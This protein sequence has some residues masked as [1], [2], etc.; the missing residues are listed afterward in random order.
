MLKN[1][2]SVIWP[3]IKI[4]IFSFGIKLLSNKKKTNLYNTTNQVKLIKFQML[5]YF[6]I[7]IHKFRYFPPRFSAGLPV[8][9]QRNKTSKMQ[10][11][12]LHTI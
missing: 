5:A 6:K 1:S 12:S 9:K 7:T 2:F 3:F 10:C 8:T 4:V 11:M